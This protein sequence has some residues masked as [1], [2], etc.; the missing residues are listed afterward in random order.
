MRFESEGGVM[1][2]LCP[3]CCT[4]D[5]IPDWDAD[6]FHPVIGCHRCGFHFP[7]LPGQFKE[8]TLHAMH[9]HHC[10]APEKGDWPA[11]GKAILDAMTEMGEWPE[12]PPWATSR[13]ATQPP[14]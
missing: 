7:N 3:G 12:L 11:L 1:P 6:D 10:E 8:I 2:M 14:H 13:P 9:D 4:L 5:D